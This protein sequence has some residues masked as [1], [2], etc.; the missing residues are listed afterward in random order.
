[1]FLGVDGVQSGK[2]NKLQKSHQ[3]EFSLSL[4]S[5]PSDLLKISDTS[6]A[7]HLCWILNSKI[8]IYL[9]RYNYSKK[10][11]RVVLINTFFVFCFFFCAR[12]WA[13]YSE[14]KVF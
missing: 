14:G 7:V 6:I 8:M 10:K 5:H 9:F 4:T 2:N 12:G 3:I 1:M 13:N 11:F